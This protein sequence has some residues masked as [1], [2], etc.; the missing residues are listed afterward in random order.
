MES[1]TKSQKA[2]GYKVKRQTVKNKKT[3]QTRFIYNLGL[4]PAFAE[5]VPEDA[6]FSVEFT[7]D[8][9]LYRKVQAQEEPTPVTPDWAV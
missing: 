4:H 6:R 9:I 5:K 3:D 7:E 8:G 1:A 2:T